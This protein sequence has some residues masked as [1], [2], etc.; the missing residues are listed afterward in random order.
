MKISQ[1]TLILS[2]LLGINSLIS[3]QQLYRWSIDFLNIT[4]EYSA[5]TIAPSFVGGDSA[6]FDLLRKEVD[7][8]PIARETGIQGDVVIK[9]TIHPDSTIGE[10][11]TLKHN[12]GYYCANEVISVLKKLHKWIPANKSGQP[13]T[14][15][16]I[17]KAKFEL[18]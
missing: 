14:G 4:P 15:D 1:T 16:Y 8:P 12:G 7:Y 11:R 17:L 9:I 10:I 3:A 18:E 2:F 6:L 5:D 13:I